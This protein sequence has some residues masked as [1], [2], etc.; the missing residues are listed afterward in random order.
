MAKNS[1]QNINSRDNYLS[2]LLSNTKLK[3]VSSDSAYDVAIVGGRIVG[4]SVARELAARGELVALFER[5]QDICADAA[6]GGNSGLGATGY[7]APID[8][9]ERKLLIRSKEI[10][11]KLY[12]YSFNGDR[13]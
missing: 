3:N 11:P 6:T 8:S 13:L 10:H 4:I 5:N 7:D 1:C 9:L 12:R 2:K